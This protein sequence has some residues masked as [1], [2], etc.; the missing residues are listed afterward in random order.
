[1]AETDERPTA[2]IEKLDVNANSTLKGEAEEENAQNDDK[3]RDKVNTD[4][5]T[6]LKL[7]ED[8]R[9]EDGEIQ[10]QKLAEDDGKRL[11]EM[12]QIEDEDRD[13]SA[14]NITTESEENERIINE[15]VEEKKEDSESNN[16]KSKSHENENNDVV[17]A[18]NRIDSDQVDE[19]RGTAPEV[20]DRQKQKQKP[21]S[22]K[23]KRNTRQRQQEDFNNNNNVP[24]LND[25][26]PS[27]SSLPLTP[28][29]KG[30]LVEEI[31]EVTLARRN[32]VRAAT[33]LK[34]S[35]THERRKTKRMASEI[36]ALVRERDAM[37]AETE[38]LRR[39]LKEG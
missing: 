30:D 35:L 6:E 1:M 38:K 5:K 23:K 18:G 9:E 39:A 34:K 10:D 13:N 19:K 28:K 17:V 15:D 16:E 3:N 29:T 31:R 7:V 24:P 32:A 21:K 33:N 27:S 12:V 14:G 4:S 2:A 26:T 11:E 36:A 37:A 20:T 8:D 25:S 22:H